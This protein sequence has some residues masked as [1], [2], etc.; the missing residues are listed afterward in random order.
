MSINIISTGSYATDE[1]L[2]NESLS[3]MVDTNDKWILERTG[4]KTRHIAK[5]N[6][7][8]ELASKACER[9]LKDVNIDKDEIG[10]LLF[11]TISSDTKVPSS[12]Y[13]TAG[14]LGIEN[15]VCFDVNAACSGFIYS[16][17]IAKSMMKDMNYKYALVVGSERLSKFIDWTDRSSCILFGD[18]AGC[19]LLENSE[20]KNELL[21]GKNNSK[22]YEKQDEYLENEVSNNLIKLEIKDAIL[23]GIYDKKKYLTVDSKDKVSDEVSP[24]IE[25]N[26]R[27]IYKFATDIGVKVI[28]KLLKKNNIKNEDIAMIVPHQANK[29]IIQ[30]LAEKSNLGIEKWFINLDK[31]GNTSSASV[32]IALDEALKNTY[33]KESR[34]KYL[35]SLA[36]GGGLSYGGIL[37]KIK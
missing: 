12:S 30:T 14:H 23:G 5:Y 25:M 36:F 33:L 26:G 7:T 8:E 17:T 28:D 1:I 34:G 29:R 35:L 37:F 3:K 21:K 18:G 24:F 10:L 11:A 4:I 16:M 32:P 27:Q 19:A 6:T 22:V 20:Y 2:D 9:A 15:A 31:Y 13:T